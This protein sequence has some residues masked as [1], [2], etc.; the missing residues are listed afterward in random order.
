MEKVQLDPSTQTFLMM[1]QFQYETF[2]RLSINR[3]FRQPLMKLQHIK[4]KIEL[5]IKKYIFMIPIWSQ[6]WPSLH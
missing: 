6:F 3:K 5:K 4:C 1:L 2:L